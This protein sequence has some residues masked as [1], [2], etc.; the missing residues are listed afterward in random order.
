LIAGSDSLFGGGFDQHLFACYFNLHK[1]VNHKLIPDGPTY[2]TEDSDLLSC[3]HPDFHPTD[4]FEDADGSL[5]ITDT[6]GWYKVCC[7][8]SQLA[9]PDVLGAVYR[10]RKKN[11]PEVSDP[12][13]TK[14]PWS[15]LDDQKLVDLLAD[16]RLFVH[17]RATAELRKR[18]KAAELELFSCLSHHPTP[19]VRRR[20][21]WTLAGCADSTPEVLYPALTDEDST[22]RQ[23][24]AHVAGVRRC[25]QLAG[26]LLSLIPQSDPGPARAAMEALGILKHTPHWEILNENGFQVIEVQPGQLDTTGAP[27]DAAL[28]IREHSLI[29]AMIETNN[30]EQTR[31]SLS[32]ESPWSVRAAL[33]ALNEMRNGDLKPDDVIP[34]MNDDDEAVRLTAAWI[35]M[36][37]PDWGSEL[38]AYF[39]ERLAS[40]DKLTNHE[41]AQLIDQ[42]ASLA[43]STEIQT[44]LLTQLQKES[45]NTAQKLALNAM[46][47]SGLSSVPTMWLDALAELIK[48]AD[49]ETMILTIVA[50]QNLPMPKEDHAALRDALITVAAN[51]ALADDLRLNAIDAAGPGNQL[52]SNTFSLLTRSLAPELPMNQRTIAANQLASSILTATQV[53]DL[54]KAVPSVGPMELPKLLP[55]FEQH[56]TEEQGTRLVD[57]LLKSEGLRG[58]RPDLLKPLLTKY[59]ASVQSSGKALVKLLNAGEEE[60]TAQ[61]EKMLATL[62][63]GDV[64]RGHEVFTSKKAACQACHKLG[65]LGG[66]LGPDLTS[67]ARVRN[68]R[69]LLEALMFP[70]ASIVR[71]Y[72]PVSAELNDGR[73]LS[74]IITSESADEIVLS[75]DAQKVHHIARAD[76]AGIQPSNVSPMPNGLTTLLTQQELSDLITFLLS[77][78]R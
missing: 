18:G 50:V 46:A 21:V 11:T 10:V 40:I 74:G 44:L 73:V 13:G 23:A 59:P 2:T 29:Y 70:S 6:G 43:S 71:G 24:A 53:A 19:T 26:I 22:V 27:N 34:R 55:A 66:R 52:D 31:A 65:Y 75:Q 72:E 69:D 7:P 39:A 76:I 45:N 78:Q 15:S 42:L 38:S 47:Q 51:D 49:N 67:I 64:R 68:R 9:K 32:S 20:A 33:V 5:L 30:A 36:Q 3:D 35:V 48:S 25:E 60:Q 61:L 63:Q 17:R 12:L 14:V 62:P 54:I 57:S 41:R 16:N 8:T 1:V 56:P 58:L 28:R 77:D 37:H 4:V